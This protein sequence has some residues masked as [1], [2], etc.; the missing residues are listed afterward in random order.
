MANLKEGSFIVKSAK[1]LSIADSDFEL[2]EGF[3]IIHCELE[4][5]SLLVTRAQRRVEQEASIEANLHL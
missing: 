3:V 5:L 4:L 1:W 2:D